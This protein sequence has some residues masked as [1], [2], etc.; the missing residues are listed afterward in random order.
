[1]TYQVWTYNV[2]DVNDRF[3]ANVIDIPKEII[4]PTRYSWHSDNDL[5]SYLKS[6][7]EIPTTAKN[8]C[9][10][11]HGESDYTLYFEYNG[12]PEF[13]LECLT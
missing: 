7:G 12:K 9:I 10:N 11:V 1:M 13:E 8:N 6:I 2:W 3:K 5:I 4:N